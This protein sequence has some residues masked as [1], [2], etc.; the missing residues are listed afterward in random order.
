MSMSLCLNVYLR[1]MCVA[2]AHGGQKRT[3]SLL[4][5]ELE[6]AASWR[7]GSAVRTQKPEVVMH[8][9]NLSTQEVELGASEVQSHP[10]L[11]SKYR[12]CADSVKPCLRKKKKCFQKLLNNT[13]RKR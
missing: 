13:E 4:R 3:L 10:Q 7:D 5:L 8:I 9:C 11:Q 1:A 12:V 2:G 6:T